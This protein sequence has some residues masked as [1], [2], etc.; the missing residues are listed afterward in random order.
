MKSLR[1]WNCFEM[2]F[3]D[4]ESEL[5]STFFND[6]ADEIYVSFKLLRV[7][8][9]V[10]SSFLQRVPSRVQDLGFL[11]Y[12]SVTEWFE[13]L[14]YVVST[15]QNLQ[16]LVVS[17]KESQFGAPTLHLPCTIW[18]L[19]QLRHLKLDKSYVIDPPSMVKDNMR[20]LSW[21]CSPHCR[22]GVY[23]KF[24]N[25]EK[26]KVSVFSS[27]NPIV[28]DNLEYL[29][30]LERLSISVAFGCVVTLPKP[31]MF[32]SQLK[33]LRLN[34][35][36]LS[37]SDLKAIEML[38]QFKVLKLEN[39]FHGKVWIVQG[40]SRLEFLLLEN[41][42]LEQWMVAGF[43]SFS[44]LEHLVLRSCYCLE[45]IPE[46]MK[47]ISML[48]SIELQRCCPSVITSAKRI[49]E[50]QRHDYGTVFFE[51]KIIGEESIPSDDE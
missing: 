36:N 43:E 25:I 39:A 44:C 23:C 35:T 5:T 17:R 30:C 15:N 45:K 32:P 26:F 34:G 6:N 51:I 27:N 49:Q 46:D 3:L 18:E 1:R 38:P 24:P 42:M 14:D 13:G 40:F 31:S 12:L 16:T 21:V 37:G 41:K 9:F 29:E 4:R 50:Y 19:P 10:P 22:A 7:L 47:D 48:K 2:L 28:L 20:T 8:A 11:R 33:K